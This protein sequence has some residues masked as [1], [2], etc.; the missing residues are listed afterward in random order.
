MTWFGL[1]TMSALASTS[2]SSWS[3]IGLESR[4][5]FVP[6]LLR[7]I[8]VQSFPD[9]LVQRRKARHSSHP[10]PPPW[11]FLRLRRPRPPPPARPQRPAAPRRR[12]RREKR[13]GTPSAKTTM[14]SSRAGSGL[15]MRLRDPSQ[16]LSEGKRLQ[17]PQVPSVGLPPSLLADQ[18]TSSPF[19]NLDKSED[20]TAAPPVPMTNRD[21]ARLP[22]CQRHHGR[23]ASRGGRHQGRL[24]AQKPKFLVAGN[25]QAR[26]WIQRLRS[27][28]EALSS[29]GSAES[30]RA[31]LPA[32]ARC[33]RVPSP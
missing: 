20:S 10:G 26:W 14:S 5:V 13:G 22:V 8:L 30:W 27:F 32:A 3:A 2:C 19:D 4:C 16:D 31:S 33:Q 1:S 17:L 29:G 28:L 24:A 7:S 9:L 25:A 11:P 18:A 12:R 21:A 6:T 15:L 23:E